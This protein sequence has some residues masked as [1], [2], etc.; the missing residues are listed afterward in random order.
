MPQT[1]TL[2]TQKKVFKVGVPYFKHPAQ[3]AQAACLLGGFS[4]VVLSTHCRP[5]GTPRQVLA[6]R[7]DTHLPARSA[8]K[9]R[10][11]HVDL[12]AGSACRTGA[13]FATRFRRLWGRAL[14]GAQVANL[15]VAVSISVHVAVLADRL[16][17][18][19][20]SCSSQRTCVLC[21]CL[22]CSQGTRLG[23][24]PGVRSSHW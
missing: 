21:A 11:C 8:T 22:I 24:V 5:L 12:P 20:C 16:R 4:P 18:S 7:I 9:R 10:P 19:A 23:H 15:G 13:W 3:S 1:P 17:T 6:Y 2:N 14:S